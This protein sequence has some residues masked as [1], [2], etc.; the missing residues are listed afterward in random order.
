MEIKSWQIASLSFKSII[1]FSILQVFMLSPTEDPMLGF[2]VIL[3]Y[4]IPI[5][6]ISKLSIFFLKKKNIIG[7]YL[8]TVFGFFEIF[9]ELITESET[10][11]SLPTIIY[12]FFEPSL[13]TISANEVLMLG[14]SFLPGIFLLAAG[15]YYFKVESKIKS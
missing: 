7:A 10:I 14:L 1:V 4:S 3:L 6:L 2:F 5:V 9:F 8:S 13:S 11:Y 12:S 15:I